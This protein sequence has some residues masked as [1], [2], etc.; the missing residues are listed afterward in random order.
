MRRGRGIWS[1]TAAPR[2]SASSASRPRARSSSGISARSGCGS[3][4][5]ATSS[6][7]RSPRASATQNS[8]VRMHDVLGAVLEWIP[9][10]EDDP[11]NSYRGAKAIVNVSALSG[12]FGWRVSRTPHRADLFL[13]V[14]V[15]PTKEMAVA[16]REVLEWCAALARAVPR[17]RRRG[18][19]LRDRAGRGDRGGATRSSRRSTTSHAE[20]F[21]STPERD[22]TRWFSD[23]AVLSRYGIATVNY[24]TSTGLPGHRARREPRHR[25][26]RADRRGLRAGRA[27]DLRMTRLRAAADLPAPVDDG[28]CRPSRPGCAVPALDARVVGRAGRP[29]SVRR[30]ARRALR[31]PAH[32]AARTGSPP[33]TWDAIPGARGCTPESCGFRDHAE[34]L[35]AL[36]AKVAGLSVAAARR[37]GR[38]L[39]A[40]RDP[41]PGDL[42][43]RAGAA[44]R[45]VTPD[46]RVRGCRPCTSA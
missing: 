43:P 25:R 38:A 7:R 37:P 35:R 14:R 2:T 12:G 26:A 39:G 13:D 34:E 20:V 15:P 27:E 17:L 42:R 21:G 29:R 19:G 31:L 40:A 45:A 23:A 41:L 32:A 36:G 24:G 28:A 18:R 22:V 3:R 30:R 9:T 6:T 5:A 16:R 44:G 8:L 4:R 11:E 10:W 46:V 1:G 33:E